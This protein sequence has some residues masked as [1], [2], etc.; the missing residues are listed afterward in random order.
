M[1]LPAALL[2]CSVAL[3]AALGPLAEGRSQIRTWSDLSGAPSPSARSDAAMVAIPARDQVLLFGGLGADSVELSDTWLRDAAG[4]RRLAPAHAPSRRRG[5][6][7]CYDATND[8]VILVGGWVGNARFVSTWQWDGTDWS[9]LPSPPVAFYRP[10]VF[11]DALR[12]TVHAVETDGR[13]WSGLSFDGSTWRPWA[14]T[15]APSRV[16]SAGLD[17]RRDRVVALALE[18]SAGGES[19]AIHEFD[20]TSWQRVLGG[21]GRGSLF[22]AATLVPDPTG[23]GLLI[24]P[25]DAS[26]SARTVMHWDGARLRVV[27]VESDYGNWR[28][29][30]SVCAVRVPRPGMLLFG[31]QR[32]VFGPL[33][34]TWLLEGTDLASAIDR[35]GTGCSG[36]RGVPSLH[37]IPGSWPILGRSLELRIDALPVSRLSPPFGLLGFTRDSV[38]GIPLPIDL[39]PIGMPGCSLLVSLEVDVALDNLGGYARWSL[40]I[41]FAPNLLG[42]EVYLQAFALD[43]GVNALGATMSNGLVVRLGTS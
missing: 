3:L 17:P 23:D 24:Q 35:F 40:P 19:V 37:A 11:H 5:Q 9:Q 7:I 8:R 4:W 22:G 20:G 2:R 18:G 29:Q 27:L 10:T 38:G 13:A 26:S 34:E 15:G 31:G 28:N 1:A 16:V 43:P 39:A 25:L 41:P 36:S 21:I 33:D 32:G 30:Q 6:G 14:T 42:A 12:N